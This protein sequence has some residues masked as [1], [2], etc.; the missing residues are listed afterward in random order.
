[1][2][3]GSKNGLLDELEKEGIGCIA[4]SPLAQ[5]LLTNKYLDGIPEDSRAAKPH[6]ELQREEI[7]GEKIARVRKL[8]RIARERGQTLSQM[9]LVWLLRHP[10]MT[11]AVV[12]ASRLDH[13]E[14]SVAALDNL[15][16]SE[17][18]LREIDRVL[19]E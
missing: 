3:A 16:L 11:S 2:I 7:T 18:E 17:E 10:G 15:E 6:G 4:F 9:A 8:T 5:G 13:I 12:G 14:E 1:M 19:K